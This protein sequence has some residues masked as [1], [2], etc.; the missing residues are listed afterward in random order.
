MV[1]SWI[2]CGF[3]WILNLVVDVCL[4][5]YDVVF[6]S[7][8]FVC[9]G[10]IQSMRKVI[11]TVMSMLM[12]FAVHIRYLDIRRICGYADVEN[13]IWGL[14]DNIILP[15]SGEEAL[16]RLLNS[17]CNDAYGVLG[18]RA[19]CS[20]EDI[21]RH[22]KKLAALLH[23]D[24]NILEGAEEAYEMVGTA[25]AAI[26]TVDARKSYNLTTL[27]KNKLHK[28][29][30]DLWD[31]VRQRVEEARNF[32]YCD[33]GNRHARIVVDIKQSEARYCRKC[34]TRHPARSNDIWVETRLCGFVW[35]YFTC[36][37]G[38]IYDI[39]EWATCEVNYLKHMRSN[40]HTVQYRLVS[41]GASSMK[42]DSSINLQSKEK[43]RELVDMADELRAD[44]EMVAG[45]I[46][47]TKTLPA[48]FFYRSPIIAGSAVIVLWCRSY[49][50]GICSIGSVPLRT[51]EAFSIS[52]SNL[53]PNAFDG[54]LRNNCQLK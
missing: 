32:M 38:I 45:I 22:Y 34:R 37:D 54:M 8:G 12:F 49:E 52:A 17:R 6:F 4:Q 19:D 9:Y 47:S 1:A 35:M 48:T 29:I 15:L 21:K 13:K 39:T 20:D 27:H 5:V 53:L 18:L 7:V 25:F 46:P 23:P 14:D 2:E 42:S 44:W 24:K 43:L 3:N 10:V 41:P 51:Q 36:S 33:C 40:S 16:D 26:G 50:V 30:L 11:I 28:D 31:R